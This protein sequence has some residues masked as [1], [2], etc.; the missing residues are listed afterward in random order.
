M[1][2]WARIIKT[3]IMGKSDIIL[4]RTADMAM[5]SLKK[6]GACQH[7]MNLVYLATWMRSQGYNVEIVDLEVAPLSFLIS[8]LESARPYLVGITAMTPNISEAKHIC[9]IAGSLKIKTV[10]GG[11]HSTALPAQTLKEVN[12]DYVVMGEGE[13]PLCSLL[14]C[15]KRKMPLGNIAGL[16]FLENDKPIINPPPPLLDVNEIPMPDRRFLDLR[17]YRGEATPGITGRKA[18]V[19][20]T[21]RGCPYTCKFCASSVINH[22]QVRF[23]S[24]DKV[25]EEIDDIV[26]LGF[27]H[28]SVEDDSFTLKRQRIKEFC[29]YLIE[30]YPDITWNCLSRVETFD[31][32]LLSLM[33]KSN[34]KK[35][36]IG[37]ESGSERILKLIDKK[38][39]IN[40]TIEMFKL[41]KKYKILTQAFFMIGFPEETNEDIEATER[42][43][44]TINP[45][46]LFLS[47]CT[48]YPGTAIYDQMKNEGFLVNEN[49]NSYIFF[50]DNISW[51][52]RYLKGEDLVKTRKRIS[53]KFYLRPKYIIKKLLMINSLAEL[54]YLMKGAKVA[55]SFFKNR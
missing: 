49:W 35:I 27:T 40:K 47:I 26:K 20:F 54:A 46:L 6:I 23:K 37:V 12:C 14:D 48:P 53:R 31:A 15:L 4:V 51:R 55:I 41:I 16:A 19:M 45:G 32:E 43:I 28:I 3:K 2:F 50:G 9:E 7:P 10:I 21:S 30:R 33:K 44:F 36:A 25:F 17:L 22:Q 39:D 38:I 13:K 18:A 8:K 1:R 34:C 52:T 24:M 42:L 11:V 5:G 29:L